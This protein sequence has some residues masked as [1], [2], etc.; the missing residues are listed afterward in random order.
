MWHTERLVP[1]CRQTHHS[2]PFVVDSNDSL[3][4]DYQVG[5]SDSRQWVWWWLQGGS[6][7]SKCVGGM[8]FCYKLE[9]DR[10]IGMADLIRAD[11]KFSKQSEIGIFGR[12][13][14]LLLWYFILKKKKWYLSFNEASQLRTH[15]SFQWR[16]RNGGFNCLVQGQNNRF[17]PCQL[18]GSNHATLQ[19]TCP[20]L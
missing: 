3:Y 8:L 15:S 7:C 20:T 10:L 12:R 16:P 9:V 11:F 14:F 1:L 6:R 18:G 13:L 19:L 2:L 4:L 17:S 5:Y